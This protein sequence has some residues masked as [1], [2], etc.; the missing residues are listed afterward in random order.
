MQIPVSIWWHDYPDTGKQK[1]IFYFSHLGRAAKYSLPPPICLWCLRY[2]IIVNHIWALQDSYFSWPQHT[3]VSSFYSSEC[4][5]ALS[6]SGHLTLNQCFLSFFFSHFTIIIGMTRHHNA[7][8]IWIC[9]II[10][11]EFFFMCLL[12]VCVYFSDKWLLR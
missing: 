11:V 2:E 9:L 10:C 12:S 8:F 3:E 5:L 7:T 4:R 1:W 6:T